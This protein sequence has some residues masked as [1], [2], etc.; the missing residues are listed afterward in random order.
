MKRALI[1]AA[2]RQAMALQRRVFQGRS[3][4]VMKI[5]RIRTQSA[6]TRPKLGLTNRTAG[7]K[8]IYY[9]WPG[10]RDSGADLVVLQDPA[11]AAVAYAM[12]RPLECLAATEPWRSRD[13]APLQADC[14]IWRLT[15]GRSGY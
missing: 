6:W 8:T 7:R 12:A 5:A 3:G 2:G 11:A 1:I 15:G 4:E 9:P 14:G 10:S 13:P